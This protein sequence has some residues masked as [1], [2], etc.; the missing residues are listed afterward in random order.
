MSEAE[1]LDAL[2][3]ML[4]NL[5]ITRGLDEA[6]LLKFAKSATAI[7]LDEGQ[8]PL[9]SETRDDRFFV[10]VSGKVRATFVRGRREPFSGIIREGDFFGAEK[11]LYGQT[12]M[13]SA[14]AV[15]PTTLIWIGTVPLAEILRETP[16]L[17]LNLKEGSEIYRLRH[18]KHFSWLTE[19]E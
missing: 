16:R 8:S 2:I 18:N 9:Y 14:V 1:E 6:Q 12:S 19:T 10:V 3:A 7:Q 4:S 13:D 17:R 15:E 11:L 5:A